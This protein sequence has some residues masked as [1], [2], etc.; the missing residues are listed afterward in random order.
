MKILNLN[1][2]DAHDRLIHVKKEQALNVFLGAEE[3][4]KQNPLSLALQEKSPYVY[5]FAHPRTGED[6]YT[7]VLYWQPRLSRPTPQTNSYLFRAQSKTD[8][9]EICWLIPDRAIWPQFEKGK[10][11]HDEMV[12]WSINQYRF[13]K[14]DLAKP[15]ADDLSEMQGANILRSVIKEHEEALKLKKLLKPT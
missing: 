8:L 13:N 1:P 14:K 4:L 2:F 12:E 11:T 6:G 15:H 5:L 10:V 7:K 3:C 9:I